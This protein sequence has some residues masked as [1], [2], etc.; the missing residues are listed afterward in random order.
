MG[1]ASLAGSLISDGVLESSPELQNL[2][3]NIVIEEYN[4]LAE[5]DI[6]SN[7]EAVSSV[8]DTFNM[9]GI[10]M[11]ETDITTDEFTV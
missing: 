9:D 4:L 6:A 7:I 11:Y 3:T 1:Y 10:E 5:S 8:T 2:D